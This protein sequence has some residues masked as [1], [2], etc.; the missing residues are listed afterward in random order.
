M[1]DSRKTLFGTPY[2]SSQKY[3]GGYSQRKPELPIPIH[4]SEIM[5]LG[6]SAAF[7]I[8]SANDEDGRAIGGYWNEVRNDGGTIR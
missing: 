7:L 5:M 1:I 6:R 4:V 2:A 8:L 3:W